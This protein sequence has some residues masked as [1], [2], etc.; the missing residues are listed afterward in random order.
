MLRE[1]ME[2]TEA[3]CRALGGQ[4]YG[5][6]NYQ[7]SDEGAAGYRNSK[8][9]KLLNSQ[10]NVLNS[11]FYILDATLGGFKFSFWFTHK[12]DEKECQKPSASD[13][14]FVS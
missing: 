3:R 10:R 12:E 8:I 2:V 6:H 14:K 13:R 9:C 7:L 1:E 4:V 11:L 5:A